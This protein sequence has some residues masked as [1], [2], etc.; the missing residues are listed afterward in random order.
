MIEIVDGFRAH[1]DP[2]QLTREVRELTDWLGASAGGGDQALVERAEA[3]LPR[4]PGALRFDADGFGHL[5]VGGRTWS[6]GR[7]ETPTVDQLRERAAR[8]REERGR[9]RATLWVLDGAGAVTDI[10]GLQATAPEGALFQVASQFNCLEAPGARITPVAS[11]FTDPTQGPRASISA[12]AGAL[13]RH[14]AAP[15]PDGSRFTQ[16]TGDRQVELLADVCAGGRARV[17][18]GYLL[19]RDVPDPAAF[20][21]RLAASA[22]AIRVGV[23]EGVEVALGYRWGGRV[24]GRRAIA[25]V[26]TSTVA[27][28]AYGSFADPALGAAVSRPLLGGAYRGTLLAAAA[29]G[30][31]AAVLTLIGGGVFGNA[32]PLI[33]EALLAAFDEVS[34]LVADDLLVIVN[35]RTDLRDDPGRSAVARGAAERGGALLCLDE[36][37]VTALRG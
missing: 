34:G 14:Y 17:R 22:G 10:G 26:F 12:F 36:P 19:P 3:A 37:E 20:A 13:L 1:G 23:H 29:L 28:G 2:A 4:D 32:R 8:R 11:Y 31:R 25:Q 27:M 30:R 7:F 18:D 9:G 6:A 5:E 16:R 33:W 24:D 35:G 15:A 21:A